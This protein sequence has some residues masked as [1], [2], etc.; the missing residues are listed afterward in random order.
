MRNNVKLLT[1]LNC[2]I[3]MVNIVNFMSILLQLKKALSIVTIIAI[4]VF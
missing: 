3:K 1:V 2:I 4:Y